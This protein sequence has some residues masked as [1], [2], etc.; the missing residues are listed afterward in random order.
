MWH[1][2]DKDMDM[3]MVMSSNGRNSTAAHTHKHAHMH[4]P[5]Q[6]PVSDKVR[7]AGVKNTTPLGLPTS[8][9]NLR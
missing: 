1:E 9:G 5:D 8:T 2:H 7:E 3:D 6:S 4:A